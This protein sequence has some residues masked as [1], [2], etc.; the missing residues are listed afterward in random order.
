MFDE[1]WLWKTDVR[2]GF[3]GLIARFGVAMADRPDGI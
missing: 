2:A 3:G 1:S